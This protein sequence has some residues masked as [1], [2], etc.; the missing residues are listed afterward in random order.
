MSDG[1]K[2]SNE[3]LLELIAESRLRTERPNLPLRGPMEPL[4]D[5][6][7]APN[8]VT[9]S[10]ALELLQARAK[11]AKGSPGNAEIWFSIQEIPSPQRG[12]AIALLEQQ[13]IPNALA[14]H[15]ATNVDDAVRLARVPGA[16]LQFWDT[17]ERWPLA[18][19]L[20][21]FDR[22]ILRAKVSP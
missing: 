9:M 6:V 22:A 21:A 10:L 16:D 17:I 5:F 3:R 8:P 18:D 11:V 14:L 13:V 1:A 4:P 15:G 20:V 7:E 2:I 12:E 19:V